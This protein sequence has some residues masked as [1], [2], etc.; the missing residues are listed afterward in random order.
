MNRIV[1][2]CLIILLCSSC[3]PVYQRFYSY[4]PMRSESQR[5]CSLTCQV[6]KQSC[7]NSEN[8]GY[9]LCTTRAQLEYQSCKAGETWGWNSKKNTYE[10]QYNCYCYT[11]SCDD[12]NLGRCEDDYANCYVGC[13]GKVTE[14]TRCVQNCDKAL[15]ESSRSLSPGGEDDTNVIKNAP[16][17]SKKKKKLTSQ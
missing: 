5:S 12:P 1:C 13:G 6:I 14:T 7:Q 3:G 17:A 4:Q 8:Q 11:P 15:P 16:K 10:C 9:E 2:F